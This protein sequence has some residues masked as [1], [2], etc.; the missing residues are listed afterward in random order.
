MGL[1]QRGHEIAADL[2]LRA[3]EIAATRHER[4]GVRVLDCGIKAAGSDAAGLGMARVAL[5]GEGEVSLIA[6]GGTTAAWPGCPWPTVRVASERAVAACLAAQYAGWKVATPGYFAMASG[7]MRAAIGREE[8]FDEIGMRER[9]SVAV[10]LLE[11]GKLPPPEVCQEL[12]AAA[13]VAAESLTLLAARTAS[14]AGTLQ[15][16]ARSLETAIHKLHDVGFDLGRIRGGEGTAPLPPVAADDLA[17]IGRTNDAIL[18][19]G[20]AVVFVT[21]DDA[22]LATI[23]PRAI[24]RASQSFGGSFRDIF[25]AAGGDFYAIDP[26]LFAPA[27]LEF[28]NVET[29]RRQAFGTVVPEI[30]A[31]SFTSGGDAPSR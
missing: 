23:G 18:Y 30:V 8:L 1:N 17:A 31:A 27:R 3:D 16:V 24:S 26:A 19:G 6:A 9:P 13:G 5:G 7:P 25:A 15:I 20:S 14:A 10:G 22:D 2:W 4:G 28:V 21:G 29:G 12:A 11:T